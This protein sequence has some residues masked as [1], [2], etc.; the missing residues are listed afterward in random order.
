MSANMVGSKG[1]MMMRMIKF[2]KKMD[3]KKNKGKSCAWSEFLSCVSEMPEI[4]FVIF[5]PFQY[6]SA[7]IPPTTP[8]KRAL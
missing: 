4:L 7:E 3:V 8:P 2:K 1:E 6:H 5:N